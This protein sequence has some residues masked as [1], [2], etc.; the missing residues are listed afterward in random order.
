MENPS[1]PRSDLKQGDLG[2]PDHSGRTRIGS[3]G[4]ISTAILTDTA[5]LF[6]IAARILRTAKETQ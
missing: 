6:T 2:W 4:A 3:G 5:A 1:G